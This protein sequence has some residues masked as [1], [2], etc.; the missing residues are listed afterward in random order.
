M[1]LTLTEKLRR[2]RDESAAK[3]GADIIATMKRATRELRE[4][5]IAERALKT[6][7]H[8][9]HFA[10]SN[11]Q[12]ETISSQHILARR[13]LVVTFY[14]GLWCPYCNADLESLQEILPK[15]KKMN[16][17]LIAVSPERPEFLK[18]TAKKLRVEFDL[19]HDVTVCP[20]ICKPYTKKSARICGATTG[21]N[22]GRCPRRRV[23]SSGRTE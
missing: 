4:S 10:L 14:R 2:M 15:I 6:G 19:L 22:R 23:S 3:L 8:A 1:M 18:L 9:P 12:G 20:T 13:A 7:D 11:Q 5:G 21:T 16:A 17:Y